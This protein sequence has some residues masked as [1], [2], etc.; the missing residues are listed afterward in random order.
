MPQTTSE[1]DIKPDAATPITFLVIPQ[2]YCVVLSRD[3]WDSFD[4][5]AAQSHAREIEALGRR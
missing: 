5:R 1:Y 3:M 2:R 4:Y